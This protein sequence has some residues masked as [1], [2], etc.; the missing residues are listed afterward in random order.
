MSDLDARLTAIEARLDKLEA[1]KKVKS[2]EDWLAE[3]KANLLFKHIDF[4]AEERKIAIWKMQPKNMNRQITKRFWLNWLAKVDVSVPVK[5][6]TVGPK[7][8]QPIERRPVENQA[9]MPTPPA[10]VQALLGRIGKG[11]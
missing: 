6:A 10:E 1:K 2:G 3:L 4:A 8:Y 7:A 5:P 11:M 9:Y